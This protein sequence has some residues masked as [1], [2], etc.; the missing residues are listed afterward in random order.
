MA[1]EGIEAASTAVTQAALV[2]KQVKNLIEL[3]G[4]M[5]VKLIQSSNVPG[6]SD[7]LETPGMGGRLD[8]HA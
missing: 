1:L 6:P 4:E 2:T 7:L 5:V 8:I 3:Q